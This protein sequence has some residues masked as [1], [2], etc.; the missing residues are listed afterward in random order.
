MLLSE[1]KNVRNQVMNQGTWLNCS[2]VLFKHDI[3]ISL[4]TH[5]N[6][7]NMNKQIQVLPYL[8]LG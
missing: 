6:C 3:V 7:F 1:G 2:S 5:C 4:K 8:C